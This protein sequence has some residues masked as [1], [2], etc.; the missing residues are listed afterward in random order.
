[1]VHQHQIGLMPHGKLNGLVAILGH[2]HGRD[3]R[4]KAKQQR[5]PV[6]GNERIRVMALATSGTE[7]TAR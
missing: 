6:A 2:P 3:I 4:L 5:K 1:M 7:G